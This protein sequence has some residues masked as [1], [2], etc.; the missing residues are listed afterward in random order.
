[1]PGGTLD[2]LG[3]EGGVQ[4]AVYLPPTITENKYLPSACRP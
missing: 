2:P 1:V 4:I 3:T